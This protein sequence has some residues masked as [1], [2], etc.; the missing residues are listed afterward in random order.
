[1]GSTPEEFAAFQRAEIERWR[2]V[3]ETGGIKPE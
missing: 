3:I 1:V 2:K